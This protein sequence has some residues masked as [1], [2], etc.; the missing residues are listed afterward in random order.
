METQSLIDPQPPIF[1][2]KN[3]EYVLQREHVMLETLLIVPTKPNFDAETL[4]SQQN[5][6][7]FFPGRFAE[8]PA[9]VKAKPSALNER[10]SKK[11]RWKSKPSSISLE[12][13]L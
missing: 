8:L 7:T 5:F 1:H 12:R 11:S 2:R 4:H 10:S 9:L 3:P 6:L 13:G